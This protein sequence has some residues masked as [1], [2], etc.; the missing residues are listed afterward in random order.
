MRA[1]LGRWGRGLARR[2]RRQRFVFV[3]STGRSGTTTLARLLSAHPDVVCRHEPQERLIALSTELAHGIVDRTAVESELRAL[4]PRRGAYPA[5]VYGESDHRLFNLVGILA[6]LLPSARFLWLIRDGQAVVASTVARGWYGAEFQ[7]GAWG[8]NR[9]QGDACGDV[10]P[11]AW[12]SLSPFE[13]NCWY[14]SYVN[15]VIEQQLAPMPAERWRRVFLED[16]DAAVPDM[17]EFIGVTPLAVRPPHE[18]RSRRTV[19]R[20]RDWSSDERGAFE[21]LCGGLM[22]RWYGDWRERW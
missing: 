15:R 16:L 13:R 12:A 4:Y 2:M 20:P 9:L 14:W 1:A 17:F 6:E 5:P 10:T 19:S 8:E 3:P 7:S 22:D 21:R 18:N 11:D